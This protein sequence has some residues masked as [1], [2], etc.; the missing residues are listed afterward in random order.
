MRSKSANEPAMST[1]TLKSCETGPKRR[2]T[3]KTKATTAPTFIS[4][5]ITSQPP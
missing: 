1:C 4:P 5:L 2:L 3:R